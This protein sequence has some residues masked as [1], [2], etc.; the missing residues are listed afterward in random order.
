[1]GAA[2][3]V[4]AAP[5]PDFFNARMVRDAPIGALISIGIGFVL[6]LAG[7]LNLNYYMIEAIQSLLAGMSGNIADR[8]FR[9]GGIARPPERDQC[10]HHPVRPPMDLCLVHHV[11]LE[12]G[13]DCGWVHRELHSHPQRAVMM[14]TCVVAGTC[15]GTG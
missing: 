12:P 4:A 7:S 13:V 15:S 3:T 14:A 11:S 1:M 5:V 10:E 8:R 6:L 9:R 2:S